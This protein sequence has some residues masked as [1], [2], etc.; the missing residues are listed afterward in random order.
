MQKNPDGGGEK[1]SGDDGF[2]AD[3]DYPPSELG[4][5]QSPGDA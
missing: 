5:Q 4:K 2:R 3:E 1:S